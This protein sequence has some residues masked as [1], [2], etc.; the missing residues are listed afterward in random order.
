MTIPPFL[1]RSK[2]G[3]TYLLRDEFATAIAA[4]SVNGT[5]ATP[6]PGTRTVVDTANKLSITGGALSMAPHT[7]PAWDDPAIGFSA[8][9][10]VPGRGMVL[11]YTTTVAE[12]IFGFSTVVATNASEAGFYLRNAGAGSAIMTYNNAGAEAC[13]VGVYSA[14]AY[15]FAIWLRASG[16]FL[17]VKGA[18]FTNWT[19][20]WAGTLGTVATLYPSISNDTATLTSSFLRVPNSLWLPTPLAS[21]GFATAFGT[22]NGAGH[23]ETSGIGS[24]GSGLTW[25]QNLGVWGISGA[26]ANCGTLDV[27]ESIGVATVTLPTVNVVASVDV[28]RAAG[29]AG[30][31]LRWTDADNFLYTYHDGTNAA[32]IE[33]VAGTP[34]NVVAPTAVAYSAGKPLSVALSGTDAR[35]FYN[36]TRIGTGSNPSTTNITTGTKHGLWSNNTGPTLDNFVVYPRGNGNEFSFLDKFLP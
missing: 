25:T 26:K 19:L 27:G 22:T 8:V 14:A 12:Q 36:Y 31:V 17:F 1:P 18:T 28:T 9:T 6:G 35:L 13:I 5:A 21:D 29:A 20:L 24:G 15:K 34:A 11:D 10:R 16:T 32:L 33:V 7:T 23:A 2:S 4:G 30:M 3:I